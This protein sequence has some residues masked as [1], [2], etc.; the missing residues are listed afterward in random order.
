MHEQNH[1]ITEVARGVPG[2]P[3]Y[4]GIFIFG[5]G[6]SQRLPAALLA[7]PAEQPP[8]GRVADGGV[9]AGFKAGEHGLEGARIPVR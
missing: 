6:G 9:R 7:N 4:L 2:D 1:V 3:P 5:C 8:G